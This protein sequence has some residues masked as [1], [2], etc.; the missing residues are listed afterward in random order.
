LIDFLNG[1][2][3]TTKN[4]QII[5]VQ[6]GNDLHMLSANCILVEGY[7]VCWQNDP[8]AKPFEFIDN[9]CEVAEG[10][11]DGSE[12]FKVFCLGPRSL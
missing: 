1:G 3:L 6:T 12:E 2:P 4:D 8:V 7:Q 10:D 9:R 11:E 5:R